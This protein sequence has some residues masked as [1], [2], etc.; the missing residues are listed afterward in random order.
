MNVVKAKWD[1]NF[2]MQIILIANV[3]FSGIADVTSLVLN[4]KDD[5]DPYS[6]K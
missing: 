4:E 5:N 6:Y 2:E 3:C 1:L